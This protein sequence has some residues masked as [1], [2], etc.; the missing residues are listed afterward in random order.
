MTKH[1]LLSFVEPF[2]VTQTIK[3]PL[4]KQ[5]MLDE[6]KALH[7]NRTWELVPPPPNRTVMDCK[8]IFRVKKEIHMTM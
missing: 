5:A 3:D 4:W 2:C 8:W 1:Q 6:I 7:H